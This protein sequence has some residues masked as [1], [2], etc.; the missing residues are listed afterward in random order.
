MVGWKG[1]KLEGSERSARGAVVRRGV[2]RLVRRSWPPGV[3]G[4]PAGRGSEDGRGGVEGPRP[5]SSGK[6]RPGVTVRLWLVRRAIQREECPEGFDHR[7]SS[8]EPV[9]QSLQGESTAQA[10]VWSARA[11]SLFLLLCVSRRPACSLHRWRRKR[12]MVRVFGVLRRITGRQLPLDRVEQAEQFGVISGRG[13][14]GDELD[15]VVY[16]HVSLEYRPL[17]VE[18]GVVAGLFAVGDS[19]NPLEE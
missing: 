11:R 13:L 5:A 12:A 6:A 17:P 3:K 8:R 15:V 14:V 19:V 18:D 16:L 9:H 1:L 4:C 2:R 10:F 7:S